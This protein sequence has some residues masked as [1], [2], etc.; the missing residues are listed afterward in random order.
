VYTIKGSQRLCCGSVPRLSQSE[1]KVVAS[2]EPGPVDV[3]FVARFPSN[4]R[5]FMQNRRISRT[6]LHT[7]AT[8]ELSARQRQWERENQ[9]SNRLNGQNKAHLF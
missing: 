9:K 4:C 6:V 3:H 2:D 8:N 5:F 7:N 1:K